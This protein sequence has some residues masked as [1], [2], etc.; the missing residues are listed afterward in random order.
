MKGL[1]NIL[2]LE[3]QLAVRNIMVE[4]IRESGLN[5]NV[6]CASGIA[7]ARA[8][9]KDRKW[10][11]MV[12]DL[13]LS[14]GESL[15]LIAELR[16]Q[17]VDI[18]IILVSG[19]LSSGKLRRAKE[20]GISEILHKPFHPKA[21]LESVSRIL[22]SSILHSKPGTGQDS[23]DTGCKDRESDMSLELFEMDRNIGIFFR[24]LNDVSQHKDVAH[25]CSSVLSLALDMVQAR[26]GYVALYE[27]SNAQLMMAVH[28]EAG[29]INSARTLIPG[30]RLEDTPFGVFLDRSKKLIQV[31]RGGNHG[32]SCWPGVPAKDY[33]AVPLRLQGTFMGV[34]CLMDRQNKSKLSDQLQSMLELLVAQ[35]DRLLDNCAVHAS[36]EQSVKETLI[37]LAR[38]LEARDKYTQNH[39]ARVAKM[40]VRFTSMLGLDEDTITLVRTG[41]LMH[42]IGKAGIPDGTLLK[43]GRLND[44]EFATIKKHPEIGD[45]ILKHMDT[46]ARERQ[47]VRYH[48]ERIDG[49]GYPDGLK[50]DNIPFEARIVCVADCIDAMT[51]HRVYQ[52]ARPLSFVIEQL[53]R[54]SGTQF[55]TR[56]AEVAI[57][58]IEEGYISTQATSDDDDANKLSAALSA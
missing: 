18:P 24:M 43:P 4:I 34:L 9:F 1:A 22:G 2:V 17:G 58:A 19:F 16:E 23:N 33:I 5:V 37:A 53:R 21:L 39:T 31:L 38:S 47:I 57:T 25:I 35:T 27:R 41:A 14:D 36:L 3:D 30:C 6:E 7:Q 12:S 49:H 32:P 8:L 52:K 46:L 26:Y 15:D 13:A 10:Q 28:Q 42:D 50:G 51:T 20:L 40:A 11:G 45:S 56:V 44:D 48:H 54:N 55:D 29:E